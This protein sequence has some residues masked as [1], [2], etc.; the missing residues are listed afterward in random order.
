MQLVSRQPSES[1]P[2]HP[3]ALG[4]FMATAA[5]TLPSSPS[6]RSR[7]SDTG[8]ILIKSVHTA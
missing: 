8:F 2:A 3:A 4:R 5:T 1:V 7:N 6:I